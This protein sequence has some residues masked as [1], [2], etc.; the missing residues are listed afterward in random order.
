M[1]FWYAYY[2]AY[3]N[4]YYYTPMGSLSIHPDKVALFPSQRM[5]VNELS[6][7]LCSMLVIDV[8]S[9]ELVHAS[10]LKENRINE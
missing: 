2:N 10:N 5:L 3:G 1:M 8:A 7:E 6:T 9:V 4:K